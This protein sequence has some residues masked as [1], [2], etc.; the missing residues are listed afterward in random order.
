MSGYN[1]AAKLKDEQD[2]VNVDLAGS[3]VAYKERLNMPVV[4]EV[5]AREQPE[6]S[7][8]LHG[9]RALLPR[10]EHPVAPSIRS[11]LHRNGIAK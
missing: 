4:A 7:R 8:I 3:G 6:P 1:I 11:T 10:A 9:A 5:V 2:K